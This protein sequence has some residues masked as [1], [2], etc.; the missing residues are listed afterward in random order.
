MTKY[1]YLVLILLLSSL[2]Y[3][4]FD[5]ISTYGQVRICQDSEFSDE[6][7]VTNKDDRSH[8]YAVQTTGWSSADPINFELSELQQQTVTNVIKVPNATELG[9]YDIETTILEDTGATKVLK[10]K[11]SVEDCTTT[12]NEELQY[13]NCQCTPTLIKFWSRNKLKKTRARVLS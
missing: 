13:S 7:T 8:L 12:I 10:Q 3:A 6:I 1:L 11:I 2:V 4:D 9:E 5:A